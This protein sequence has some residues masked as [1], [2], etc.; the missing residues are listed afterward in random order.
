MVVR[1]DGVNCCFNVNVIPRTSLL[2]G[3]LAAAAKDRDILW[4]T[5]E[6]TA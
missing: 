3:P 2:A 6:E 1:C 4:S 5:N